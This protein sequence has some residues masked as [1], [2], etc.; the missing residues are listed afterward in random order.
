MSGEP[1]FNVAPT[2][3]VYDSGDNSECRDKVTY[4]YERALSNYQYV[5][6]E[7]KKLSDAYNGLL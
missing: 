2:A 7:K 3:P 1:D 5:V 4:Y 6:N